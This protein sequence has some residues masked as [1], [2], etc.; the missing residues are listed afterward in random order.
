MR[1]FSKCPKICRRRRE[2]EEVASRRKVVELSKT[3]RAKGNKGAGGSA[4][5]VGT[6]GWHS[7]KRE[8]SK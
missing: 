5:E 1:R 3:R 6:R 8:C 2:D 7:S 4:R